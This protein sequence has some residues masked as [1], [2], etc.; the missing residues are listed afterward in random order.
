MTRQALRP[1]TGAARQNENAFAPLAAAAAAAGAD[2]NSPVTMA[3]LLAFYTQHLRPDIQQFGKKVDALQTELKTVQTTLQAELE[4]VKR[5]NAALQQSEEQ[6]KARLAAV[7]RQLQQQPANSAAPTRQATQA[8][9]DLRVA[10]LVREK[11]ECERTAT[12][13]LRPNDNAN[14]NSQRQAVTAAIK[15]AGIKEGEYTLTVR[16]PAG[17]PADR[18]AGARGPRRIIAVRF[19]DQHS[20]WRLFS[21][22]IREAL[23][24]QGISVEHELTRAE[25]VHLSTVVQPLTT[26]LRTHSK[27]A[28]R[29]DGVV[30]RVWRRDQPNS[31]RHTLPTTCYAQDTVPQSLSDPRL[32]QWL[33]GKLGQ[34][35][36]ASQPT[37]PQ[38]GTLQQ[39]TRPPPT[40]PAPTPPW[41]RWTRTWPAPGAP[42]ATPPSR[43]AP[44]PA[45]PP[46]GRGGLSRWAP[47]APARVRP[48]P[49]PAH[50]PPPQ[51]ARARDSHL[52]SNSGSTSRSSSSASSASTQTAASQTRTR[53]QA[54]V[55]PHTL[56]TRSLT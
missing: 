53:A 32:Q 22:A 50:P 52:P 15:E 46:R 20:K 33:A 51:V 18:P 5:S 31:T 49:C 25:R 17:R 7:E 40:P 3:T 56:Q 9:Q 10:A 39:L 6:L 24:R 1:R 54:N 16:A 42:S 30:L 21:V 34:L 43:P 26:L 35:G 29:Y 4:T 47:A 2:Q 19:R 11:Q 23:L 8:E 44:S 28:C 13:V 12:F 38:R 41:T 36:G 55:P 48:V 27:V 37:S 14:E 45:P